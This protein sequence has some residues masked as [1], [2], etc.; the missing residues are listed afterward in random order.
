MILYAN[1]C[2]HTA[3]AEAV[4]PDV[5][6]VDD[7]RN[8]IDRRPHPKNLAASWCSHVAR[9]LDAD[10]ICD[11]ESGSSNARI[12]RTT[13]SWVESNVEKLSNTLM[14]VQWTTWEREEWLHDGTWF[15]VNASGID[16]VPN[17]LQLRYKNFIANIDWDVCTAQAHDQ[18]WQLHKWLNSLSVNHMFFSGHSTFR[19]IPTQTQRDWGSSYM[20]PYQRSQSYHNWL[21]E[22]GGCYANPQSYHFDAASHR[23]WAQ[24]VL[25]YINRNQ[26]LAPKHEILVD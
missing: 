9:T 24:H 23:L 1:G 21:L 2:S 25:Q 17:E 18:I 4:V 11:A 3:A 26:I 22:N 7:G 8:G 12:I 6:A 20:H 13:K 16:W 15:Q 14:I 19:Y 5:F 10:L